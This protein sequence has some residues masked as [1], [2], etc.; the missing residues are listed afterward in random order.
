ME[1][2]EKTYILNDNDI[3]NIEFMGGGS[4]PITVERLRGILDSTKPWT[5]GTR[6]SI[7]N[8]LNQA[9]DQR[10]APK[11]IDQMIWIS[12]LRARVTTATEA[13]DSII[14]STSE[15][16]DDQRIHDIYAL[17][18]RVDEY[19]KCLEGNPKHRK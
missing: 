6:A 15:G 5:A 19:I 16:A 17:V 12:E 14:D 4:D 7:L 9:I 2:Q 3:M 13:L 1:R 11:P 10:N 8:I 18:L